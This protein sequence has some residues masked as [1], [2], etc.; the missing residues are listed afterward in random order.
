NRCRCDQG[1]LGT[2]CGAGI[3]QDSTLKGLGGRLIC[4]EGC[5]VHISVSLRRLWPLSQCEES[6]NPDSQRENP[7]PLA[8]DVPEPPSRPR[9]RRK[10]TACWPVRGR[11]AGVRLESCSS[12]ESSN[13]KHGGRCWQR[14]KRE[15]G[16]RSPGT[17]LRRDCLTEERM[18]FCP[19]S[20]LALRRSSG[21]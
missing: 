17:V 20:I 21:I 9:G 10:K 3:N 8:P 19:R 5:P 18:I 4:R 15:D 6:G 13:L 7:N 12:S 1:W 16:G 2:L 14:D 11:I